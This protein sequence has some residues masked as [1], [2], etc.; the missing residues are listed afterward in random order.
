MLLS[1]NG[2]HRLVEDKRERYNFIFIQKIVRNKKLGK[3]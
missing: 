2:I 1:Q 3:N